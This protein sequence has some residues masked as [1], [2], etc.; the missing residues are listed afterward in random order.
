MESF[1]FAQDPTVVRHRD[2]VHLESHEVLSMHRQQTKLASYNH[3][4]KTSINLKSF[5]QISG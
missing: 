2:E 4:I 3:Y 5:Q 1:H